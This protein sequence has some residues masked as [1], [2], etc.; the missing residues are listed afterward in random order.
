[1]SGAMP[2]LPLYA[3]IA[4]CSVK[5]PEKGDALSPLLFHFAIQHAMRN[6][7]ENQEG[8]KL[9]G[10]HQLLVCADDVNML[11][12][13]INIIKKNTETLLEASRKVRLEVNTEKGKYMVVSCHQ[14]VGQNYGLLTA[15]KAF[16]DVAKFE[17]FGTTVTSKT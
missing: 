9:D 2:P 11:G 10:T 14:N 16:E 3:F 17:Y 6:V 12:E 4:W 5:K 13:N 8:L 1:M 15:D 7:Q